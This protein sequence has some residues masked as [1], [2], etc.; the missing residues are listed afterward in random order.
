MR[1]CRKSVLATPLSAHPDVYKRQ[2]HMIALVNGRYAHVTKTIYRDKW[3]LEENQLVI[4]A[5]GEL[6]V[7][8]LNRDVAGKFQMLLKRDLK[9]DILSLIHI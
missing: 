7:E 4:Y 5:L 9:E 1:E 3:H 2:E 8:I 6:S